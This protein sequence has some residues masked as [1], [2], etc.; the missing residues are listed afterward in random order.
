MWI[1]STGIFI[2]STLPVF[3]NYN[4]RTLLCLWSHSRLS[5]MILVDVYYLRELQKWCLCLLR[6]MWLSEGMTCYSVQV[7]I[8]RDL[9]TNRNRFRILCYSSKFPCYILPLSKLYHRLL[10]RTLCWMQSCL[11]IAFISTIDVLP[12]VQ[13]D[14]YMGAMLRCVE[15]QC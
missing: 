10:P 13:R 14:L 11:C 4:R 1:G 2:V 12:Y 9:W 8:A 5:E 3:N 7:H 15:I 6:D